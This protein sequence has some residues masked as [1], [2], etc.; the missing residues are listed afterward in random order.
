MAEVLDDYFRGAGIPVRRI[1]AAELCTAHPHAV[2]GWRIRLPIGNGVEIVHLVIDIEAPFSRPVVYLANPPSAGKWPHVEEDG[3]LCLATEATASVSRPLERV[4]DV[5]DDILRDAHDLLTDVQGGRLARDFL[6]EW[7]RYWV[8]G[9]K[10]SATSILSLVELTPPSRVVAVAPWSGYHVV[11]ETVDSLS[12][13]VENRD[14]RPL[15]AAPSSAPLIFVSKPLAP[16][17]YPRGMRDLSALACREGEA[18]LAALRS[19]AVAGS[20]PLVGL[21]AHADGHART[22]VGFEV[23]DPGGTN[24]SAVPGFR[25]GHVPPALLA[26]R[27]L[28]QA[29]LLRS[30][31]ARVDPSWVHGRDL[32]RDFPRLREAS[33]VVIGCGSLGGGVARLLVQAGVGRIRLVDSDVFDWSNS[34][35]HVLGAD[36]VDR[37]KG[38]ALAERLRREFPHATICALDERWQ[39]VILRR[40]PL[41]E[42]V[43]LVVAATGDWSAEAALSDLQQGEGPLVAKVGVVYGWLER[44]GHAAHAVLL[45]RG[46]PCLRCGFTPMGAIRVPV[47]KPPDTTAVDARCGDPDSPHGATA[48]VLAQALVSDLCTDAL[49]QRVPAGVHRVWIAPVAKLFPGATWSDEWRNTHGDPADGGRLLELPWQSDP[50][51]PTC[52][53]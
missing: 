9:D 34:A 18:S 38:S 21:L 46:R 6:T 47:A 29:P 30:N 20:R 32:N 25:Q 19:V 4:R 17:E 14:G 27:Y 11:A 40:E 28:G 26:Q 33:V 12:K 50:R 22:V 44:Y 53:Q 36:A 10:V 45:G 8:L 37:K 5:V 49:A 1:S 16:S 51:C 7:P 48:V 35:R 23:K 39:E 41:F 31:A 24:A 2:A 3:R 42:D 52:G 43:D 15:K 13:W